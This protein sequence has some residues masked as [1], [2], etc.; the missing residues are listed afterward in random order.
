MYNHKK[1]NSANSHMNCEDD[2]FP[3]PRSWIQLPPYTCHAGPKTQL[4]DALTSKHRNPEVR[5][6]VIQKEK[7]NIYDMKTNFRIPKLNK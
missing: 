4:T 6:F 2:G 3:R 5:P 1:M 7:I